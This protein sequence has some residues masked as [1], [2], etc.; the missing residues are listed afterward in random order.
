MEADVRIDF[1][2]NILKLLTQMEERLD[3][4]DKSVDDLGKSTRTSMSGI[5]AALQNVSF[6]SITQGLQN[7]AQGLGDLNGPGL[8]YNASLQDLSALTGITGAKLNQLGDNARQSAKLFGGNAASSLETYKTILGRLGPDIAKNGTALSGMERDVS[9]LSKTMGGDA[10]GAVD[11]LTTAVLQY[12]VDLSDAKGAQREMTTM[13][14]IMAASAKEGAA[15]VPQISA[16]LKVSGVAAKQANVSFAETNA[17]IQA[18]AAGGKEGSEAGMALR[19]VLGKMAGE[20]VI[21]K[22][23]AEKLRKLGVDMR[24][25]SNTTLPFTTRL[26]ELGKAQGDATIM[27]QVFGVENAAAANILLN[28]VNAQDD[29]QKKIVGTHSAMD[30]AKIVMQSTAE[31]MKVMKA[32]IDDVKLSFFEATGGATAYLQP[33]TE[34]LTTMSAFAPVF[35]ATKNLALGFG[36]VVKGVSTIVRG[37]ALAEEASTVAKIAGAATT[38]VITAAQWLWNAAMMANPI[39]VIIAGVV[40][41]GAA[42]YGLTKLIQGASAAEQVSAAVKE[43]VI[44]KTADQRAELDMLFTTLR[45]SKKGSDEYNQTLKELDSIQPGIVNKYNLQAGA[46]RDIT[47]A[48]KEMIANIDA[49]AQAEAYK[50]IAKDAYKKKF[51][52]AAK[53]PGW[54]DILLATSTSG[55]VTAK[56][57]NDM[58]VDAADK[59]AKEAVRQQALFLGSKQYKNA[60][61]N[62]G[63]S[64]GAGDMKTVGS[65]DN[66]GNS[67]SQPLVSPKGSSSGDAGVTGS[68]GDIRNINVTIQQLVGTI[69]VVTNNLKEGTAEIKRQVTEAITGAV[70]DFE[71]SM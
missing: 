64:T 21:P 2:G 36:Q 16:A 14:N 62:T 40:A 24:I 33:I 12:Q 7:V 60:I 28:S 10:A 47:A 25:V 57:F 18:L 63:K 31:K 44:E 11:A 49:I 34:V 15:E 20:D 54:G 46:M 45:N 55:A 22:E 3:R 19:N 71:T 68:G 37:E 53:G 66:N 23:A 42:V 41:L 32:N 69:Q 56:A 58:D 4:V 6:V 65:T 59:E 52:E 29:L 13:M 35:N 50:E 51:T 1:E 39:G 27:A 26:R 8:E 48:Q 17:A 61:K 70:R 38:K 5:Q 43:K 9:I 30:Q 67:S